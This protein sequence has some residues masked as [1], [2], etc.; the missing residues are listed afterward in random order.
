MLLGAGRGTRLAGL[1]LDVPKILV[2]ISGEPLLARQLR[3][4]AE[5]GAGRVVLNAHHLADQVQAFAAAH[6][7]APELIV[8]PEPELLGTAGGVRNA[9]GQFSADP[10]VV[11]YGDVLT[12]A[13]LARIIA[14]HQRAGLSATITVYESSDVEGKGTVEVDGSDHLIGFVEKGDRDQPGQPATALIN[15]GLYVLGRDFVI[16]FVAEG[17]AADFGSDVFPEA[18]RRGRRVGVYRLRAPVLDVG[19]P[20]NL[21][22]ARQ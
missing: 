8:V 1:G 5:Q 19:T 13:P 20:G 12:D 18:L 17:E 10:I 9:I 15:A 6:H 11:L 7:G 2:E 21:R 14:W 4:L 3:Y 22:Q 16:E